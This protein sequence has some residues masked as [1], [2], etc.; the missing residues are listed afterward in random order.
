MN[1][2]RLP[3]ASYR[4]LL[5]YHEIALKGDNRGRFE[6]RLIL[7][8]QAL[9][10]RAL[11]ISAAPRAYR[12]PGRI[13]IDASWTDPVR[14][15]LSRV[16]GLSSF[17]PA[18]L[19]PTTLEALGDAALEE[20]HRRVSFQPL[21]PRTFRVHT[22]TSEKILGLPS[23]EIDRIIGGRIRAAFPEIA[24]NLDEPELTL[25]I[26][27][28]TPD[29]F[30]TTERVAGP[31]G[32]PVGSNARLLALISGGIDSPV[33]AIEAL[34][35][36][37]PLEFIHFHGTPF[38]GPEVLGKIED[39]VREIN[40][41]QPVPRPL[42][43]VPF[44]RIQER[45]ALATHPKLR[46]LLYRRMMIRIANAA[47]VAR[48]AHAL[49]TGDSVG[50]VASQTIENL[51]VIDEVSRIPILRPL[52]T[53]DKDEIIE[54]AK[55]WGTYPSSTRPGVDCCTLFADR[56]PSTRASLEQVQ[57]QERKF[58]V[59]EFVNEALAGI[60]RYDPGLVSG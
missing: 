55:R 47:A 28:R 21:A 23:H 37:C 18:R 46:T 56:H 33:A 6:E 19:V 20:F 45:I 2:S 60:R 17:S 7:N 35:R 42:H 5:R 13:L 52:V 50:Q 32:L 8:A 44:G 4:V 48:K 30:V 43:L 58:P 41:F 29:S 9:V 12:L 38:V 14:T 51:S 27:I 57:E 53:C 11:G 49:V 10:T 31:G 36:G 24:V 26:E 1:P 15:A 40:A 22:R 3:N 25:G 39:L 34:R 59:D 54:R 16:F